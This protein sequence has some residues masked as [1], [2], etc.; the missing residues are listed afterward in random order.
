MQ[1]RTERVGGELISRITR[2]EWEGLILVAE[3]RGQ[4][5]TSAHGFERTR[6]HCHLS[7]SARMIA[8]QWFV[9]QLRTVLGA[10]SAQKA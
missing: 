4:N 2:L 1:R 7:F 5:Q 10:H 3:S 9:G 8:V 6:E